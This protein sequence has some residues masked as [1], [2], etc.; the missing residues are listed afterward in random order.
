MLLVT[1]CATYLLLCISVHCTA[2]LFSSALSQAIRPGVQIETQAYIANIMHVSI[3]NTSGTGCVSC[4][5]WIH[6][7]NILLPTAESALMLLD[8]AMQYRNCPV[9]SPRCC[10]Q[11]GCR[12]LNYSR[13][14]IPGSC[15][16]LRH[17]R[18][19]PAVPSFQEPLLKQPWVHLR[20]YQHPAH[21]QTCPALLWQY[22]FQAQ[23]GPPVAPP[24][25]LAWE[26]AK[27]SV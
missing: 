8:A 1:C 19:C 7:C 27:A 17:H 21:Q 3:C 14:N 23:Q 24:L 13:Q 2:S 11:E 15:N 18:S 12:E 9:V 4:R 25:L 16:T 20:I 6:S 26:P 22:F 10:I 5:G